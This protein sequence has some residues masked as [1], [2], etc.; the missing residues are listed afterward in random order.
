MINGS[1]LLMAPIF[2]HRRVLY[3]SILLP[4]FG[5][6]WYSCWL[7]T[8]N[9]AWC[10]YAFWRIHYKSLKLDRNGG[11]SKKS[12]IIF[13]ASPIQGLDSFYRKPFPEWDFY[14]VHFRMCLPKFSNLY[15]C[16][17]GWMVRVHGNKCY[18]FSYTWSKI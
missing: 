7:L 9:T 16:H 2:W 17:E 15:H 6:N 10:P 1:Y 14:F 3:K 4:V 13:V 8:K 11:K 12:K 18:S 5:K